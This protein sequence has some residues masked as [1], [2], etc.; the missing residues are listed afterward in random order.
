MKKV[1]IKYFPSTPQKKIWALIILLLSSIYFGN[2]LGN[3]KKINDIP[4]EEEL[5]APSISL[6]K[7]GVARNVSGGAGCDVIE[8]TFTLAN[9]STN[10][11]VL[12]NVVVTDLLLGGV[13]PGPNLGT[14]V[15]N[16][17]VMAPGEVWTYTAYYDIEQ[18]DIDNGQVVNQANVT[19]LVQGQPGVQVTDLS[20]DDDIDGNQPT[21]IDLAF[22]QA[23]IYMIK[24]GQAID[25]SGNVG[26]D[27][28]QYVMEVVNASP[29]QVLQNVVINDPKLGGILAGPDSGDTNTDGFLDPGEIWIY[30]ALYNI[31]PEDIVNGQV[32]NQAEV[33]A[34]VQGQPNVKV[35]DLSDDNSPSQN[36]LTVTSL[37]H[38]LPGI[39]LIKTG[40]LAINGLGQPNCNTVLYTFQVANESIV[41]TLEQVILNDPLVGGVVPGPDSGDTNNDTFLDPGEVWI[42]TASYNTMPEDINNGEIINQA[43]VTADVQGQPGDKVSDLSDDNSPLQN[44]P[45]IVDLA[46][47]Q[48]GI[49]LIKT[50][51]AFSASGDPGCDMIQYTFEVGNT[52]FS[53]PLYNVALND[54]LISNND[55]PGPDSGDTNNDGFLD[56]GE[57]WIYT[58][59]YN[60]LPTDIV[61]E[62]VVN[63]ANVVA[64]VQGQP[65]VTVT[66]DSDNDSPTENESTVVDLSACHPGIYLIKTGQAF[67][68]SGGP[69][70]DVIQYTLEVVNSSWIYSL[71]NVILND[72]LLGGVLAGPNFGDDNNNNSLEP[73]EI[74]TYIA[75]YDVTPTD[76]INGQVLNQADVIANVQGQPGE[77]VSDLSDDDSPIQDEQTV[78]SLAHCQNPGLGL[79]KEGLVVDADADGCLESIL[80]TFTLT[81]IGDVDLYMI[82]LEDPLFGGQIPGPL[83]GTDTNNDGILFVG[84]TWIYE[85]LYAIKQQDIVNTV[86]VNQAM[87]TAFTNVNTLVQDLSDDDN[88]LENHPTR[89]PVPDDACI[90]GAVLGLIK[91]GTLVDIDGDGCVESILYGFTVTNTGGIDLDGVSLEDPLFGGQIPGPLEGT[92]A[93]NDGILSVGETWAYEALY[94][95]KQADIDNA[96]VDN[97]ATVTAE[98]LGSDNSLF[99]LSDDDSLLENEPTSTIIPNDA[100]TNGGATLG[101]I[102]QSVLIDVTGDGC[103]DTIHY[104]FTVTNTGGVDLD[105]VNLED[106]LLGGEVLG[107]VFGT[108]VNN[109]GVLS[110]GEAWSY[111]ALYAITQN[112]IANGFILNQATVTANTVAGDIPVFDL[113]DNND[114]FENEMTTTTIPNDA[115]TDGGASLGLIKQGVLVDTNADGCVDTVRYTFT[116]TSSGGVAFDNIILMDPLLGGQITGPIIGSDQN[117]DGI[118]SPGETW[119]FEADYY[120][121]Q[122]DIDNS[123]ILNQAIVAGEPV[124]FDFQ[125]MD[126]SDNDSYLENEMTETIVP[127]DACTDGGTSIGFEIFN[128]ITPNGDGSNDYFRILGIENYPDNQLKIYNRWG[129]LVYESENYG[130]GNN[131]FFGI[132]DGRATFQKDKQ[133]PSGTYFYILTFTGT[134]PGKDSY[135]GYLYINRD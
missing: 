85:A 105:E 89:T 93:N 95:I 71:D 18:E 102:K 125:L 76:I 122:A 135:S 49:Y 128:G 55:L 112:D 63:Q 107:P 69:G 124:G 44:D 41:H 7:T 100:C 30:S 32:T 134:N 50:G 11:E 98:P 74:W 38:C 116:V 61:N 70:C 10:G 59:I 4:F 130:Q 90:D 73:G 101:L 3:L 26:C 54:P 133:L 94:A 2:I 14:D 25:I 66:D 92:D 45:T 78:V 115:C 6:I 77:T 56:P 72:P 39:S 91:Q 34:E 67:A 106:P 104:M 46:G 21:T 17:G 120:L 118:L 53:I 37:S 96:A 1:G 57:I 110:V 29:V 43:S 20:D 27:V 114:L 36:D 103:I 82:T 65:G 97:Q 131:L 13:V 62:Q 127:N 23:G 15:G 109:D 42:Y 113:S 111:E 16:D 64:E 126:L 47:C 5:F 60:I 80:Y 40:A 52:S 33:T 81:N 83:N 121:V 79:I 84:E 132:S 58:A 19:A 31:L 75:F 28:V 88:L 12:Q 35:S 24:T 129:V 119:T 51:Q 48:P 117:N 123:S 8:Y 22:C 87:A 86:V 99:D 9:Q 68:A 108:D